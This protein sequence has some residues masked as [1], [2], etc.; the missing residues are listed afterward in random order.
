VL[1]CCSD[2]RLLDAV[3]Q[4]HPTPLTRTLIGGLVRLYMTGRR[5]VPA[6]AG[7]QLLRP[8]NREY[9]AKLSPMAVGP[10]WA[11]EVTPQSRRRARAGRAD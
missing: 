8:W 4:P 3:G 2:E 7:P 11:R 9:G 5:I 1:R 10:D 6:S